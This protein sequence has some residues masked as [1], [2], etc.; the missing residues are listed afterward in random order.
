M[1]IKYFAEKQKLPPIEV[2]YEKF[3]E[4]S[5]AIKNGE[6]ID[7]TLEKVRETRFDLIERITKK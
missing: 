6:E 2:F 4:T 3:K 5:K 1:D 7:W